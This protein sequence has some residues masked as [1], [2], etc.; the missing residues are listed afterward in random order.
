MERKKIGHWLLRGREV[1]FAGLALTSSIVVFKATQGQFDWLP[2]Q[3]AFFAAT[4]IAFL[5]FLAVDG[6]LSSM[7]PFFFDEINTEWKKKTKGQRRFIRALG[8]VTFILAGI[9]CTLTFW[10]RFIIADGIVE[11]PSQSAM[12]RQM[13]NQNETFTNTQSLLQKE[14]ESARNTHNMRIRNAKTEGHLGVEKSI[15][16]GGKRLAEL[17]RSGNSWVRRTNK[18]SIKTWRQGIEKAE[19][20]STEIVATERSKVSNLESKLLGFSVSQ[21]RD[22]IMLSLAEIQV[23]ETNEYHFNKN[24]W[25]WALLVL[26]FIFAFG[27]IFFTW[28]TSKYQVEYDDRVEDNSGVSLA[29]IINKSVRT[30]G[31]YILVMINDKL[32]EVAHATTN[33]RQDATR[34]ATKDDTPATKKTLQKATSDKRQT[35]DALSYKDSSASRGQIK[36]VDMKRDIDRIRQAL[37]RAN[38]KGDHDKI[39]AL[40]N[41]ENRGVA[42][43]EKMGF[44]C[45]FDPVNNTFSAVSEN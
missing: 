16:A 45:K 38:S 32:P 39:K 35:P 20:D 9:S 33:K 41:D 4:A 40:L 6:P 15:D 25:A 34:H 31:Q 27:A 30:A 2:W 37:R 14:L 13:D 43:L 11:K 7:M 3:I 18:R 5:F 10:S 8:L 19:A 36:Y 22:S 28:M 26:D 1:C 44:S 21:K 29:E 42:W 24:V 23:S 12:L 17:W